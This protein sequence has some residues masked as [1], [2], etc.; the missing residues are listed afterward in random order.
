MISTSGGW[1]DISGGQR[2][3]TSRQDHSTVNVGVFRFARGMQQLGNHRF[4][5]PLYRRKSYQTLQNI[6]IGA[7]ISE[8]H[9]NKVHQQHR[10][11]E[12]TPMEIGTRFQTVFLASRALDGLKCLIILAL[13]RQFGRVFSGLLESRTKNLI[14]D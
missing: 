2:S 5:C 1:S 9:G 4:V 14:K 10:P 3:A 13:Q 6:W 11:A 12:K 7:R 8:Y